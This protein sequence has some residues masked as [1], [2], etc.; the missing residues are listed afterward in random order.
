MKFL[1]YSILAL[2]SAVLAFGCSGCSEQQG[3]GPDNE[4]PQLPQTPSRPSD[5]MTLLFDLIDKQAGVNPR[6]KVYIVAHRANTRAGISKRL[7]ENS[8]EIIQVAIESGVVDMVELDVRPTKDG[9]LVLM[10]D[11]TVNRTTNGT[12]NVSDLTYAQVQ[13]LDMNREDDKVTTGIKVPTLKEAFELC[14]GK[15]FINLDIH[16]KKVP[17]GQLAALIKECGMT[18]HVMIYSSKDE[19]VD[20]QNTDPNI[21]IHPYVSKLSAALE[22]KQYPGAMLFQYGLNYDA[23][24]DGFAKSMR[25]AGFL[26]YTNILNQDK[27]MLNGN[28]TYLQKFVNSETDFIQTDYAELVHEYLDVEGLR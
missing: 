20:Y 15:M 24:S 10:H 28:Y 16:G 17:V 5:L 3:A 6:E 27:Y 21:I 8:L 14:K 4:G 9:V 22:Y 18:D 19:L 26:T 12:G 11:A 23:D 1:R 25:E 13:A 7:P 2:L